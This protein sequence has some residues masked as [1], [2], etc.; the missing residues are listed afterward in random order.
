LSSSWFWGETFIISSLSIILSIRFFLCVLYHRG[1]VSFFPPTL[2]S[3]FHEWVW[4]FVK[5][6]FLHGLRLSCFSLFYS[7]SLVSFFLRQ[8]LTTFHCLL[9]NSWTQVTLLPQ[10]PEYLGL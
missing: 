10:L 8:G 7:Y 1:D 4:N 5:C 6:F 2:L 9:L 3:I